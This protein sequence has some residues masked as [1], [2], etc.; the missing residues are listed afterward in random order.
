MSELLTYREQANLTQ[1]ELSQ[2]S[3]ISVRTIQRIEAG[4]QPKGHTL[5]ALAKALDIEEAS[6]R[7]QQ[8]ASHNFEL[9]KLINLTSLLFFIPLGNIFVPLGLMRWKKEENSLTRQIVSIQILWTI[10]SVVLTLIT[11]FVKKWMSLS[12]QSIIVV[13]MLC[14]LANLFIVIRNAVE[15][16]RNQRLYI[17]LNFNFI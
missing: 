1:T 15:I 13:M 5:K 9:I 11:P 14:I 8:S 16:D 3:G 12:N 17:N 4:T 2:K 7:K 6:L 10:S